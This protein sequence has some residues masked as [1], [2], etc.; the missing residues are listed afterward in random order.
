MIASEEG[1]LDISRDITTKKGGMMK[2]LGVFLLVILIGV[3]VLY[4]SR[5]YIL[6]II[7]PKI[8]FKTAGVKVEMEGINFSPLKDSISVK[9]FRLFNPAG[10]EDKEMVVAPEFYIKYVLTSFF[11]KPLHLVKVKLNLEKIAFIRSKD[12]KFN[13]EVFKKFASGVK[14]GVP[15]SSSSQESGGEFPL[16]IDLLS[17]YI[18]KIVYKD[19]SK[20]PVQTREVDLAFSGEYRDIENMDIITRE[21]IRSVTKKLTSAA[22]GDIGILPLGKE[23]KDTVTNAAGVV[24]DLSSE[25]VGATKKIVEGVGGVAGSAIKSVTDTLKIIMPSGSNNNNDK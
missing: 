4:F 10:F 11:R 5:N 3:G 21:V 1:V 18:G 22:L 12:G 16:K 9:G 17:L 25:A 13:I 24:K 8:I 23:V 15:S 2:K 20:R 14:K 7:L 6:S 19:Y